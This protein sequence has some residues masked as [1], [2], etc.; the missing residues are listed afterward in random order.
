MTRRNRGVKFEHIIT[1]LNLK[2]R[3]RLNYFRYAKCHKTCPDIR[4]MD[5]AKIT[6][7]PH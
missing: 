5:T 2:L 3:G 7:L 6:L 4:C 1:E